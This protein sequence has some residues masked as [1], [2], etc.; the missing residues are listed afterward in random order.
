MGPA[1]WREGGRR[2]AEMER[3]RERGEMKPEI[4]DEEKAG[5]RRKE[6]SLGYRM[7]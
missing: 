6:G 7:R 5:R 4:R 1:L 2:E 3:G